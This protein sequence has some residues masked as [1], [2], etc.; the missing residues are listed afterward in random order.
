[1]THVETSFYGAPSLPSRR[2]IVKTGSAATVLAAVGGIESLLAAGDPNTVS[3][4]VY[5]NRWV[6]NVGGTMTPESPAC[7]YRMA[8]RS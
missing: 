4:T 1:M 5:E 3:G 7:W 2:D 8:A 6:A